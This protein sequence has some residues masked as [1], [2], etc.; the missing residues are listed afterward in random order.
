MNE[1]V[2]EYLNRHYRVIDNRFNDVDDQ[3]I[4][5]DKLIAKL[6][7]IF[8]ISEEICSFVLTD[9]SLENGLLPTE[10]TDAWTQPIP[11]PRWGIPYE[12]MLRNR[13]LLTF[14][15]NF[16]IQRG[17]I[18]SASRPSVKIIN[19]C[20]RWEP[21]TI[22]MHD[23]INP[24]VSVELTRIIRE[25]PFESFNLILELLGPVGDV[26]EMWYLNDCTISSID[27]GELD[28]DDDNGLTITMC[29]NLGE[30]IQNY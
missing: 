6:I 19:G 27:F 2:I 30:I 24:S 12:P 1:I 14:P 9:W 22:V 4:Y 8:S 13:F 3:I 7:T 16:N 20:V 25:T 21:M 15:Q 26:I 11:P 5:G 29:I 18:Q 23:P 10:L 17:L 28:M